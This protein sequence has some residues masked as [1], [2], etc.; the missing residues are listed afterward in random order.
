MDD[1]IWRLDIAITQSQSNSGTRQS[2]PQAWAKNIISVGGI[3][4]FNTLTTADDSWTS[5][6]SIGPAE[7]GRIKPD[8]SYWYDG[9]FTT[10]TGS[11]YTE[12]IRRHLG[13]HARERGR[14][15][16]HRADVVGQRLGHEPRRHHGLRA[17]AARVDHQGPDRSTTR[18]ST[19]SRAPR[20]T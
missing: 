8:V 10:T 2:R 7:D 15:G 16:T 11:G 9:I 18:G 6:A 14:A 1:I 3:R 17:P 19:P 5:G 13:R 4:H 12:R 20:T